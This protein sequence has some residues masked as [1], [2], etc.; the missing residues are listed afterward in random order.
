MVT[1]RET[2][3]P[4]LENF[5]TGATVS[6]HHRYRLRLRRCCWHQSICALLERLDADVARMQDA[7]REA[8]R[9]V[10]TNMTDHEPL[11]ELVPYV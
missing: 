9:V 1:D 3:F 6:H 4:A 7:V 10:L 5:S 11:P 2:F 8:S